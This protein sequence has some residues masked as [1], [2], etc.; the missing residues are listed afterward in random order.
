[1]EA[2][3][4]FE[5]LLSLI[6]SSNLNFHLEQSPFGARISLKKSAVKNKSG[7]PLKLLPPLTISRVK[8]LEMENGLLLAKSDM[9]EHEVSDLKV[10]LKQMK[11]ATDS[12]IAHLE[13][14]LK[15][16]LSELFEKEDENGNMKN[17]FKKQNE[18]I[19][20]LKDQLSKSGKCLKE[21]DRTILKLET[22][23]SNVEDSFEKSRDEALTLKQEKKKLE[24][25]VKK[26]KTSLPSS[27]LK[28]LESV[29]TISTSETLNSQSS[30]PESQ[31]SDHYSLPIS[32]TSCMPLYKT[33]Q[34]AMVLSSNTSTSTSLME[35]SEE[36]TT[37]TKYTIET[38]N[39]FEIL[40]KHK[41]N[42][43]E[44]IEDTNTK[45]EQSS[46]PKVDDSNF[47]AAFGN[48]L[49]H[50][51]EELKDAPKYYEVASQMMK[52]DYNMFHVHLKDARKFNPNLGGFLAAQSKYQSSEITELI[53]SYIEELGLGV[54][55]HGLHFN[56]ITRK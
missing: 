15:N 28:P 22:K 50:F 27:S 31:N 37:V 38:N 32:M 17:S 21:K 29:S 51:K 39:N 53:K 26:L 5:N 30:L 35:S 49:R 10:E 9:L 36:P 18:E 43:T 8:T 11:E 42:P 24:N 56:L 12:K 40:A 41:S 33:S 46:I 3:G 2:N 4:I 1:M 20:S 54:P 13:T 16:S 23:I 55:K 48:F 6:K 25:K 52:K 45:S 7:T 34:V 44:R 47:K 14:N 19:L